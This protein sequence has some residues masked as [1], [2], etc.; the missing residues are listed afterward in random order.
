[1]APKKSVK[2][3]AS[4]KTA[5]ASTTK[6]AKKITKKPQGKIV[7]PSDI[8]SVEFLTKQSNIKSLDESLVT[9]EKLDKAISELKKFINSQDESKNELFDDELKED[10][11]LILT[12][13][14]LFTSKVDF[15]PKLIQ[16]S[17]ITEFSDIPKIAL[18]VR[19]D[20]IDSSKLEE[21]ENSELNQYISQIISAKELH[22]TYKP[23]EKRRELF[24]NYDL[25]L[26][27][28]GLVTT[29]P[30]SLGKVFY[31]S[32]NKLPIPI[33][34]KK[35]VSVISILG[36]IKK[37][38]N[39]K[40]YRLNKSN[41]LN[42]KLGNI[43]QINSEQILKI[44]NNFSELKD[45]FI[46]S[47]QSPSLPLYELETV[48]S[49]SD[50]APIAKESRDE[51]EDDFQIEGVEL[52]KGIKFTNFEKSLIEL[53]NDA[54]IQTIVKDKL[55]KFNKKVKKDSKSNSRKSITNEKVVKQSIT[56]AKVTKK[57]NTKKAGKKVSN[58]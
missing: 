4:A 50:L 49:E 21:I 37:I 1:M 57:P 6:A 35:D 14:S 29:L 40:I 17:N 54:E 18:F 39:S 43:S 5:S 58:K 38:L 31:D 52:P 13:K 34:V 45:I 24:K 27:D 26:A 22:S 2:S 9:I 51:T 3:K 47:N 20:L 36:Q 19:D 15:K 11:E 48:Y 32:N 46:K 28:D 25:F 42:V 41:V 16:V 8:E 56:D 33:R 10:L 53:S 55:K 30:K 23:Y 44:I 7:K 12:K